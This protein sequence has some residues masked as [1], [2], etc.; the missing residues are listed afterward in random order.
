M[1]PDDP[2]VA[3]QI[4]AAYA[5]V[6]ER[7]ADAQ[8]FPASLTELPYARDT[9]K[10][11]IRTSARA[12]LSSGQLSDELRV[13]LEEA[14]VAL[15][16]FLDDELVRLMREYNRAADDLANAPHASGERV[17]TSAWQTLERTSALAGEIAKAAAADA[18]RLRAEFSE[19][20]TLSDRA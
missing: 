7:H 9:I 19:L 5:T 11:A 20:V 2:H 8:R 6:L 18:A 15:A 14:Y 10:D 17:K 13:F 1:N 16:D 3:Q 4:V 12:L